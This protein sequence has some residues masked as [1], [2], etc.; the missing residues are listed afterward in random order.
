MNKA[1]LYLF[2]SAIVHLGVLLLPAGLQLAEPP[3]MDEI[4]L[5]DFQNRES[6]SFPLAKTGEAA[7][8]ADPQRQQNSHLNNPLEEKKPNS[9][10]KVSQANPQEAIIP[11]PSSTAPTPLQPSV[12][13]QETVQPGTSAAKPQNLDKPGTLQPGSNSKVPYGTKP[14]SEPAVG[15]PNAKAETTP[16]PGTAAKKSTEPAAATGGPGFAAYAKSPIPKPL[17]PPLARKKGIEGTVKLAVEVLPNGHTGQV[18]VIKSSGRHDL[19]QAAIKA[20]KNF[21]NW[22]PKVENGREVGSWL[23]WDVQFRLVD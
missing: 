3:Q 16:S 1:G 21:H 19:D 5:V 14:V 12:R 10:T 15:I 18:K 7:P 17:Y 2:L 22:Q 20:L 23:N 6:T 13:E 8:V 4:E 11:Q 9:F